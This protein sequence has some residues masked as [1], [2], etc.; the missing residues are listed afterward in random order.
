[1]RYVSRLSIVVLNTNVVIKVL[2]TEKRK[3]LQKTGCVQPK[4][5]SVWHIGLSGEHTVA[6]AT[7]SRTIY[8]RRVARTN[9][10]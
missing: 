5:S 9:G 2:E 10:R 3:G 8:G 4:L 1:M 6:S 7:V